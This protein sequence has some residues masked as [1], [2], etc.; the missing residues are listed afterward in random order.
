MQGCLK[1][2]YEFYLTLAAG[3]VAFQ[4]FDMILLVLSL[5]PSFLMIDKF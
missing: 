2:A 3:S 1:K 4:F 5:I